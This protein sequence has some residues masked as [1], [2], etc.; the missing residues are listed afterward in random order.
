MSRTG[1]LINAGLVVL[2]MGGGYF[3]GKNAFDAMELENNK[4]SQVVKYF[5]VKGDSENFRHKLKTEPRESH[6]PEY[7]RELSAVYHDSERIL[8]TAGEEPEIKEYFDRLENH[9]NNIGYGFLTSAL[10]SL[11]LVWRNFGRKR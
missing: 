3:A 10:S 5:K 11:L 8:E 4:P 9:K 7:F 1:N 6:S 2:A